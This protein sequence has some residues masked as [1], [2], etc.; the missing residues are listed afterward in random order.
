MDAEKDKKITATVYNM[1]GHQ[2]LSRVQT[3]AKGANSFTI[4][5]VSNWQPGTY[6]LAIND[7]NKIQW[8]KFIVGTR[9]HLVQP[10]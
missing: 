3:L 1:A 9:P 7:E 10:R 8:L 4:N 5:E 2:I 6:L